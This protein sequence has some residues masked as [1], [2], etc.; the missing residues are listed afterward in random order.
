MTLLMP[1]LYPHRSQPQGWKRANEYRHFPL[2]RK[3][4]E[5]R[6]KV[7]SSLKEKELTVGERRGFCWD[8]ENMQ[9]VV[10]K[11]FLKNDLSTSC[12]SILCNNPLQNLT[13]SN[14]HDLLVFPVLWV[15]W[16]GLLLTSW[17]SLSSCMQQVGLCSRL[18]L[19]LLY[20]EG[21]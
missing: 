13:A 8:V 18:G 19:C 1:L 17:G 16:T 20:P 12:S 10:Y 3:K 7:C 11:V 6:L 21:G 2:D 14:E 5:K 15:Y 4:R 9:E